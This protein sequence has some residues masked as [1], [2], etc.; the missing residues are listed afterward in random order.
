[1]SS[2]Q[3]PVTILSG[4]L[5]AG[6]TTLLNAI[7]TQPQSLRIFALINDF[8]E[9]NLDADLISQITDDVISLANGCACCTLGNDL[10]AA[11]EQI[12]SSQPPDAVL[13]EAS[14]VANLNRLTSSCTNYPGFRFNQSITLIDAGS[15][16]SLLADKFVATTVSEQITSA[17]RL[18]INRCQQEA[19]FI[20]RRWLPQPAPETIKAADFLKDLRCALG[21]DKML[22]PAPD[23]DISAIDQ[24]NKNEKFQKHALSSVFIPTRPGVNL[25]HLREILNSCLRNTAN[26]GSSVDSSALIRLKGHVESGQQQYSI[27]FS[28]SGYEILPSRVAAGTVGLQCIFIKANE[29]QAN[30]AD[31]ITTQLQTISLNQKVQ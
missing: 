13:I 25:D 18:M 14:G 27:Q 2:L 15:I 3:I 8:G 31:M 22:S 29:Q 21:V 26:A 10:G 1:M 5:G 16:R 23:F 30:Q 24:H 11:F 20:T 9:V 19:S 28:P 12:L 4:Y 6:K 7:L 17:S